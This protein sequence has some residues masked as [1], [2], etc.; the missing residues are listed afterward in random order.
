LEAARR[1]EGVGDG[2]ARQ[3]VVGD[4]ST[5]ERAAVTLSP[6]DQPGSVCTRGEGQAT[7]VAGR[8]GV[9]RHGSAATP[10]VAAGDR[11]RACGPRRCRGLDLHDVYEFALIKTE[12]NAV[13]SL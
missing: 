2:H 12:P 13:M 8:I 9:A 4:D 11:S 7:Q 10:V 1:Q 6:A 3:V 5:S